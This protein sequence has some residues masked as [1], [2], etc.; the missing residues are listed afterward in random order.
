MKRKRVIIAEQHVGSEP[1]WNKKTAPTQGDISKALNWYNE[2]RDE[3]HAAKFLGVPKT[4]AKEFTTAAWV[5]R[6]LTR[7]YTLPENSQETFANSMLKLKHIQ[8]QRAGET[9]RD[10]NAPSI[11]D[12]IRMKTDE[13]IGEMEGLVD[14]YGIKGKHTDMKAYQWMVDNDVKS[15]HC[16]AI[17]EHFQKQAAEVYIAATGKDKYLAE[18]YASYGKK[19]L[20]NLLHCYADIVKDAERLSQNASRK[21]KPRK[22]KPPSFDKMVSKV[23]YQERDDS[24]KLVSVDPIKI[25]G[26]SQLWVYNTK[27]RNLGVYNAL[28]VSGLG[29]KGTTVQNYG[30]DSVAKILRKPEDVLPK[31]VSGGKVA[32]RKLMDSINAK[33]KKLTGRLNKDTILLRIC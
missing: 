2:N 26:A 10:P 19:G 32:L 6:M 13:I 25:I 30:S 9:G 11:Q 7:G 22:R 28:D 31:V 5:T 33:P 12:H 23:K 24:L 1:S 3:K 20:M 15:I 8:Q 18:A 14:D 16:A 27:T 29:M 4:I 21:R 17:I